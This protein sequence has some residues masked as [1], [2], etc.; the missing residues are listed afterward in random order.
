MGRA[1]KVVKVSLFPLLAAHALLD[2]KRIHVDVW[3]QTSTV[4]RISKT[5]IFEVLL[6]LKLFLRLGQ[7]LVVALNFAPFQIEFLLDGVD[8]RLIVLKQLIKLVHV[9]LTDGT[10]VVGNIRVD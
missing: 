1:L 6:G 10:I 7:H 8:A 3:L 5:V 4:S 9:H 2:H